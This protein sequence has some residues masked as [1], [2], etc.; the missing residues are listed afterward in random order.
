MWKLKII[1]V[2]F[3]ERPL[4]NI[5]SVTSYNNI[6]ANCFTKSGFFYQIMLVLCIGKIISY[7]FM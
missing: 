4:D 6:M 7:K 5:A 2:L 1:I 3:L